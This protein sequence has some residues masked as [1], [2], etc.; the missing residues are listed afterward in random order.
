MVKGRKTCKL[1]TWW[2]SLK[3]NRKQQKI[4]SLG[5]IKR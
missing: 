1:R 4:I 2:I 5:Q 3:I